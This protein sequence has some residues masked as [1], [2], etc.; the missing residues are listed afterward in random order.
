VITP[1]LAATSAITA[2]STAL[3]ALTTSML[4]QSKTPDSAS[5]PAS[6]PSA[7]LFGSSLSAL[8]ARARLDFERDRR[9]CERRIAGGP[10][11]GRFS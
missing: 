11:E 1:V 7:I 2:Q 5:T 9:S 6:A 3:L 10:R 4:T 8:A